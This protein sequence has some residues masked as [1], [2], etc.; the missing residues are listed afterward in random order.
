MVIST[1]VADEIIMLFVVWYMIYISYLICVPFKKT[2]TFS[3][4]ACGKRQQPETF[5]SAPSALSIISPFCFCT[6]NLPNS[7]M[8]SGATKCGSC[9][10][11]ITNSTEL[12]VSFIGNFGYIS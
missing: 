4:I 11:P 5:P 12:D 1:C 10:P 3:Q 9:E 8:L 7:S 2:L 6:T